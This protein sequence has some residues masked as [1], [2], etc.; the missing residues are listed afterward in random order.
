MSKKSRHGVDEARES[1]P[2]AITTRIEPGLAFITI[3]LCVGVAAYK[4]MLAWRLNVNWDEFYFLNHVYALTRGE[5]TLLLQGSY[6]HAFTWLTYLPG[7]EVDQVVAGRLVMVA[8]LALTAWLVWRLARL[9]LRGLPAALPPFVFLTS[10]PVLEHGGSFRSDSILAPLSVAALLILLLPGRTSRG[11]WLAGAILGVAFAV[12]VKV[13]LFAPLVFFAI[14]YRGSSITSRP[15]IEWVPAA[16]TMARVGAA[17]AI[18]GAALI[19]LHALSVKPEESQSI[20]NFAASTAGTTLLETPWFPRLA[21][22][23]RYFDWQPLPWILIAVGT[24]IAL[25]RRRFD[26]AALSL[27]LLPLAFYRNAFPYYFVVM[28]A[29]AS[30]LVGWAFAEIS[31][32]TRQ[33]ASEWVTSSLITVLWLGTVFNGLRYLDRLVFDDQRLQRDVIAGIH[34][35]FPEPVSYIDRCGMVSSFRKA[36]FFMSTWGLDVY[37]DRNTAVMRSTL[38]T[39]EPAFVLVNAPALSPTYGD[40]LGLL[41]EDQ[42]L[43]ASHYVDYWGPVRVAGADLTLHGPTTIRVTVPFAGSYRLATTEP[44]II[45][46]RVRVN[47][48]LI[49]VPA[50]GVEMARA[51]GSS[52][53]PAQIRLVLASAKPAPDPEPIGLPLFNDL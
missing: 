34:Q 9:W 51:A 32:I 31:T 8:L 50:Q 5:L 21:Y 53:G 19:G 28:L 49:E 22:F 43:L 35:I 25:V 13:V 46:D 26:V 4:V 14:L 7:H 39:Q 30:I 6:T 18:V 44:L 15:R 48:D 40:Q 45:D 27:S 23:L 16:W 20:A 3:A 2:A 41:A 52:A 29:P 24:G 12:T 10:M 36:G 47:G 1:R 38:A 37:R 42:E 11:D 17:A 33:R